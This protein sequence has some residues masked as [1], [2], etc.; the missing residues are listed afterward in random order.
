MNA[1]P[2][3]LPTAQDV[4]EMIRLDRHLRKIPF[5]DWHFT[6]IPYRT[7]AVPVHLDLVLARIIV[8]DPLMMYKMKG[9]S[10]TP[11]TVDQD[12]ILRQIGVEQYFTDNSEFFSCTGRHNLVVM[13]RCEYFVRK[14]AVDIWQH[15]PSFEEKSLMRR[16]THE[17]SFLKNDHTDIHIL[18]RYDDD[19]VH[20]LYAA[21]ERL[22][23]RT[24]IINN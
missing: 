14:C 20:R 8:I 23:A 15:N 13:T 24:A 11:Q 12:G 1:D 4:A 18:W 5:Q 7:K 6:D 21:I 2:E 19:E 10:W 3:S 9:Y 17:V 16:L 22:R